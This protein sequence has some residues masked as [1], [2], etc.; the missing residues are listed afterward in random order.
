MTEVTNLV[1]VGKAVL[2]PDCTNMLSELQDSGNQRLND[3][4][5]TMLKAIAFINVAYDDVSDKMK[6][7]AHKLTI[8][9]AEMSESLDLLK[10]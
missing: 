10:T 2:S 3:Y 4:I 7:K 1:K 9:L 8:D 6:L 5:T